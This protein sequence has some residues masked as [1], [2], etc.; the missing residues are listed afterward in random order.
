[1][2]SASG[3]IRETDANSK[4]GL[5]QR[6]LWSLRHEAAREAQPENNRDPDRQGLQAENQV[7][8][9]RAS[10]QAKARQSL[11]IPSRQP[12][13]A[14]KMGKNQHVV[15]RP[16]GWAVRGAGNSRDTS[17]HATQGEA[18]DAA[19]QIAQNQRSEMLIHNRQGRIRARDSF[20]NDPYPPRG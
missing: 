1:M 10:H 2:E 7:R 14:E 11:T 20:G 15:K 8:L 6:D 16:D 5:S 4:K 9:R 18:I 13:G 12:E 3:L 17:H 19:R